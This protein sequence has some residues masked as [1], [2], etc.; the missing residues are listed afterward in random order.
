MDKLRATL[1]TNIVPLEGLET[2]AATVG[3][4]TA[5]ATVTDRE[6]ESHSHGNTL[7]SVERLIE[8]TVWDESPW[9]GS[10]FAGESEEDCFETVLRIISNGSFPKP[11]AREDLTQGERTQ[12]R[13]AMIFCTHVREG[14]D[15]FVTLDTKAFLRDGRKERLESLYKTRIMT[16][17]Q[18][19]EYLD[20]RA[21]I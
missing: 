21:A 3:V 2:R 16:R 1:D 13:D 7:P 4:A 17:Q 15:I 18:F 11:N 9:D 19:V 12:L 8:T 10:V 14:R 6:L 5:L 20:S